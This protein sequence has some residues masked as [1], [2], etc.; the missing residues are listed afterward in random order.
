MLWK[1]GPVSPSSP[2]PHSDSSQGPSVDVYVVSVMV[3]AESP[4]KYAKE[5]SERSED[6]SEHVNE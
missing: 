6:A 4:G 1:P 3:H 2:P 5:T